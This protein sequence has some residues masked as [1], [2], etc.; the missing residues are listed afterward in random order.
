MTIKFLKNQDN[1]DARGFISNLIRELDKGNIGDLY[2]LYFDKDFEN[3]KL[4]VSAKGY[5]PE[6]SYFF[7]LCQHAL[8]QY[9]LNELS[10][11]EE[12]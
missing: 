10:E 6:L 9:D 11:D 4:F 5:T 8:L 3:K 1:K 7:A 12:D 2:V